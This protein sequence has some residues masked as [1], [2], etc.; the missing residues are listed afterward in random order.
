MQPGEVI[1]ARISGGLSVVRFLGAGNQAGRIR[2]SMGRNREAHLPA[3][4]AIL[5]T[6]LIVS[7]EEQV[8]EFRGRCEALASE[9]DLSEVWDVVVDEA[10]PLSLDDIAELHWGPSPDAAH[11]VA[12]LLRLEERDALYFEGGKHGYTPRSREA[13]R[14]TLTRR[15]REQENAREAEELVAYLSRGVLPEQLTEHQ[16]SLLDHLRGFAVHG[17]AYPRSAVARSLLDKVDSGARD[18]QRRSFELLVSAGILSQDEPLELERAGIPDQFT[19]A[20]LNEA[21][22]IDIAPLLAD[23]RR[24]DLTAMPT[25]TID[26]PTTEDRDDALSLELS[27]EPS[28]YR[29][30][31]HIADGGALIPYGGALDQEADRRMSTLYLPER[32]IPMLPLKL[33]NWAGSLVAGE[34]RVAL[35][36]LARVSE[37]GEVLDW[38]VT[39]SVVRSQAAISYYDADLA[40]ADATHAWHSMLASMERVARSLRR[41]R[42]DNGAI[43]LERPELVVKVAESGG[44]KV[45]VLPRTTPARQMVAEFMILCNSLLAEFCRREDLPAAYRSQ[46]AP[47]LSGME[48]ALQDGTQGPL[49]WYTLMR[50]LPPSELDIVPAPHHGLGVPAYIQASSPLRRYPDLVMQRQISQFISTGRPL[51]SAEMIAS[52]AQRADVQLRELARIEEERKRYWFLKFLKQSI[53][54]SP[55]K[56]ESS[57]FQ[58]IVLENQPRRPALLELVAYPF[59]IRAELPEAFKPGDAVTLRLHG[60]DLWRRVGHF[61]HVP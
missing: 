52:V 20:A 50:R 22:A 39:P 23:P 53:A 43:N 3:D 46:A 55:D 36:L 27:S 29:I 9:I 60:V 45:W 38:E 32:K 14:E 49:L 30:G 17:E 57:L 44:I 47:D 31:I 8:E 10:A 35:S 19:M 4:R 37:A 7:G 33:S 16:H 51:Y 41:R 21:A 1:V 34:R 2:V 40:L 25:V 15:Q 13:V 6:G 56:D 61:V 11:K 28:A 5:A 24:K 48:T 59:R 42:E 26:D 58:A 54:S 12:L 18:L